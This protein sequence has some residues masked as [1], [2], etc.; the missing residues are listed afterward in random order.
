MRNI[1]IL[2]VI[3]ALALCSCTAKSPSSPAPEPSDTTTASEN[4][5]FE[6]TAASDETTSAAAAE[7]TTIKVPQISTDTKAAETE[8]PV[9]ETEPVSTNID[10]KLL[11]SNKLYDIIRNTEEEELQRYK[12]SVY[13]VGGDESPELLVS[14][15][16]F[17]IAYVEVYTIRNGEVVKAGDVGSYGEV[18]YMTERRQFNSGN[19]GMGMTSNVVMTLEDG[20]INSGFSLYMYDGVDYSKEY[21]E[22]DEYEYITEYNVNGEDSTREEY[23]KAYEEHFSGPYVQL[24]R[25]YPLNDKGVSAVFGDTGSETGYYDLIEAYSVY[26]DWDKPEEMTY[27]DIDNDGTAELI[28]E[29]GEYYTV[30]CYDHGVKTSGRMPTFGYTPYE[31]FDTSDYDIDYSYDYDKVACTLSVNKDDGSVVWRRHSN[32]DEFYYSKLKDGIL[33]PIGHYQAIKLSD[34]SYIYVV[35]G[36]KVGEAEY[37]TYVQGLFKDEFE[38]LKFYE[39]A[40]G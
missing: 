1:I 10:Y 23:D 38:E 39:L 3:A 16:D 33:E 17:H 19:M 22:G 40:L 14:I 26:T 25:D 37:D 32:S 12:F 4:T 5:I 18:V 20:V 6:S 9:T 21:A 34:G 24:G 35:N 36:N 13:D 29:S 7:Q 2:P 31:W 15:G 11:Y 28:F 30:Y 27:Y 8:P